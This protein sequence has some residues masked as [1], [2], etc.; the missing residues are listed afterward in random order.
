MKIRTCAVKLEARLGKDK[1]PVEY[2][3]QHPAALTQNDLENFF[4]R[5]TSNDRRVAR[6]VDG[7]QGP[8]AGFFTR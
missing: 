4:L 6:T 8:G 5:F 3:Y 2:G 7:R 1:K